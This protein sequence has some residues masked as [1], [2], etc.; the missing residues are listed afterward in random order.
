MAEDILKALRAVVGVEHV[1]QEPERHQYTDYLQQYS[2]KPLALVSPANTQQVAKVVK[3]CCQY[4]LPL[5]P[6]AANTSLSAGALP[7]EGGVLLNM[8]RMNKILDIKP[9][10][11][12]CVVQPGVINQVLADE[13]EKI[14]FSYPP[15]PASRG[16]STIGGNIAH[17]SGGPRA[18]KYGTTKDYILNLEVVTGEG[19]V[20]Q[21][22]SDTLKNSTGYNLTALF[23]SSEGTL[24]IITKCTLKILPKPQHRQATLLNVF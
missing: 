17:G 2:R 24:G 20:L 8:M 19:E 3:L 22:G 5:T 18:V 15:D 9:D 7:V 23:A 4:Q 13:V 21:T 14:N 16:S 11:G 12:Y 1:I 10:D 6:I